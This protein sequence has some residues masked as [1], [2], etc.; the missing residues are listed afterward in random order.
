VAVTA[1]AGWGVSAE[2]S[3]EARPQVKRDSSMREKE[4]FIIIFNV[5]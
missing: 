2:K 3:G 5:P 4:R 1:S